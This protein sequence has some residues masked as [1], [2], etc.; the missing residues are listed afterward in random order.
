MTYLNN[1]TIST[2]NATGDAFGRLRVS[3]PAT[4]FDSKL[5]FDNHPLF[6]DDQEVSGSGTGSSYAADTSSVTL[7]V[8]ANTAGNR[9]RQTFRRFNYQPG[10][11]QFIF[12][13]GTL[14]ETGGGTGI[15]RLAGYGDDENGV[16][17]V[18]KEG[19]VNVR[20]RSNA[21]GTPV[22]TDV[23]QSDWNIDPLNGTGPSGIT[24]DSTKSQ[25]LVFDL[26]WL[27]VGRVRCGFV[28][29]GV[30][31]YV[32]EFLHSN[33]T[34]GVYLTTPNLPIR[35]EID[36][37]GTGAASNL[38]CICSQVMSE[39]GQ[40]PLGVTRW[41]SSAGTAL[42][43]TTENQ[44]YAILGIR[45]KSTH[46]GAEIDIQNVEVQLQSAS[47]AAEWV[48]LFDPTI[49]GS[50]S[51]SAITN[52]ALERF[53]GATANTVSNGY[54]VTGGYVATGTAA[55]GSGS[56]GAIVSANVKLGAAIDNTV[57]TIVLAARPIDG[58]ATN[59]LIE[60]GITVRE[61]Y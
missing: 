40:E 14:G 34:A 30:I 21:T 13:T 42:D 26:E 11:S 44:L 49:A 45:L 52:S 4:V 31:Y 17:F 59:V 32:H 54:E 25:I 29:D 60:G 56:G 1:I 18:D 58:S 51:W 57:Q 2:D 53:T 24:L 61:I 19:V 35:F 9:V 43:M 23:A 37:D 22:D 27:G 16:F 47:D 6:W 8:S 41:V 38:E 55:N 48:L 15:T 46:L 50:P 5:L 33:K 28:I 39:G 10:K 20:K 7:S 36:N 3:D 12:I